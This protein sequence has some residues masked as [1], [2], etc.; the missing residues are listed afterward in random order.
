MAAFSGLGLG[1]QK[2]FPPTRHYSIA[3][4]Q[5]ARSSENEPHQKKVGTFFQKLRTAITS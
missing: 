2:I 1:T 3:V 4:F 5:S